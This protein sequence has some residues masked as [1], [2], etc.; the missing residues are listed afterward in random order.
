MSV[1][2]ISK[3]YGA[4]GKFGSGGIASGAVVVV[5]TASDGHHPNLPLNSCRWGFLV[6]IHTFLPS[7]LLLNWGLVVPGPGTL[8]LW[9]V[10]E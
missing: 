3:Y 2:W 5:G 7:V 4:S 8:S 9:E 10:L 1:I 6:P